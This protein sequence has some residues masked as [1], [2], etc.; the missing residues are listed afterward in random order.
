MFSL[1]FQN[2]VIFNRLGIITNK[3]GLSTHYMFSP[4]IITEF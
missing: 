4:F 1:K 2:R 3:K